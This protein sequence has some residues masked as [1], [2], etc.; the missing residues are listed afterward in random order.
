MEQEWM[1]IQRAHLAIVRRAAD[2]NKE[3]LELE[4]VRTS[5]GQQ[6]TEDLWRMGTLMRSPFVYSSKGK[7]KEVETEAEVEVE[8]KGEE[9]DDEDE[10]AQG[11]EEIYS[12]LGGW[13]VQIETHRV[14]CV[15][16]GDEFG[17][18]IKLHGKEPRSFFV[19]TSITSP[20]D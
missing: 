17:G 12:G 9:A 16:S 1:E 14:I 11:E 10:D 4:R 15:V 3:R 6:W 7:E 20:V 13:N 18:M 19:G 5:L 2:R 8:E